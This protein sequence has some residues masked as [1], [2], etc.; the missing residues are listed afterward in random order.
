MAIVDFTNP[1]AEKWYV[2]K[3]EY[4]MD[5]GVDSFKV[6]III[7]LALNMLSDIVCHRPIVRSS[8]SHSVSRF[9]LTFAQSLNAFRTPVSCTMTALIRTACTISTRRNT[10]K[11]CSI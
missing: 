9:S 1:A 7:F 6:R 3:L 11:S 5:L 10:T 2:E 4:L 8:P